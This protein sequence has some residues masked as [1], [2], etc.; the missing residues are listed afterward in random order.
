MDKVEFVA[1][2][3]TCLGAF[4]YG[5][6]DNFKDEMKAVY[7]VEDNLSSLDFYYKD[8]LKFSTSRTDIFGIAET[9][10]EYC[11]TDGWDK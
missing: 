3:G 2:L 9:I 8:R 1:I 6:Y 7:K 5:E 11:T 4:K 10:I